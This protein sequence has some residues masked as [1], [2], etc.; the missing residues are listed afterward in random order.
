MSRKKSRSVTNASNPG[1]GVFGVDDGARAL[2]SGL[3]KLEVGTSRR[4]ANH[5]PDGLLLELSG[6]VGGDA[7]GLGG[8]TSAPFASSG[9]KDLDN[10]RR[11]AHA[12][13]ETPTLD[14]GQTLGV[15][16]GDLLDAPTKA[17]GLDGH[18]PVLRLVADARANKKRRNARGSAKR[19]GG[20]LL[21]SHLESIDDLDA[22]KKKAGPLKQWIRVAWKHGLWEIETS[23]M[24]SMVRLDRHGW[25]RTKAGGWKIKVKHFEV[26]DAMGEAGD[27]M[28]QEAGK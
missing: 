12:M 9:L 18:A 4:A 20:S 28:M 21:P 27:A 3:D 26:A 13:P 15:S 11:L 16:T 24:S 22:W 8:E 2:V 25:K 1:A 23:W 5:N 10:G 6:N 17:L 14:V 7:L 19:G